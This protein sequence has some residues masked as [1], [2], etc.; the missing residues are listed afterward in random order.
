MGIN[1]NPKALQRNMEQLVKDRTANGYC[2]YVLWYSPSGMRIWS[3]PYQDKEKAK[4]ATAMR[5]KSKK[6]FIIEAN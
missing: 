5:D 4:N 2:W 6:A 3:G 1:D